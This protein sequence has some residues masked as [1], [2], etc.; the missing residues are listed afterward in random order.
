MT[1]TMGPFPLVVEAR[2]QGAAEP[3]DR[4]LAGWLRNCL[5]GLERIVD[6]DEVGAAARE[7]AAGR[8][9]IAAAAC[10]GHELRAAVPCRPHGR[11]QGPIPRRIDNHAELAMQLAGEFVG[12]AHHNDAAGR[13]VT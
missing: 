3:V 2:Y 8:G 1:T 11:E 10:R 13:I 9:G 5:L 12:V 7:R 4:P 6:D